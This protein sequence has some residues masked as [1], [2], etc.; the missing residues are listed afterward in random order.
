MLD[1][2]R[3]LKSKLGFGLPYAD[4]FVGVFPHKD[5]RHFILW[6]AATGEHDDVDWG[7]ED[8]A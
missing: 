7:V 3:D 4:E 6:D 2:F 1:F 8:D 5:E